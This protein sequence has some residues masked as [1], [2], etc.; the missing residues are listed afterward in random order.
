MAEMTS[1]EF[2]ERFVALTL[3]SRELPRKPR[4]LNVLLLSAVL[5]FDPGRIYTER[6]VNAELQKWILSFGGG[7]GLDAVTLRRLLV[8]AKIIRRDR[9]GRSYQL[10]EIGPSFHYDPSIRGLDLHALVNEARQAREIRKRRHVRE[11]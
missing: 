11:S 3:G 9:A 7:F 4:A 8:D 2:S 6:E 5:G 10:D 1:A